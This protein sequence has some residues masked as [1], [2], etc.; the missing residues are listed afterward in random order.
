MRVF[1]V[2]VVVVVVFFGS[3]GQGRAENPQTS[4]LVPTAASPWP[5]PWLEKQRVW[6]EKMGRDRFQRML[7]YG[8][9][10]DPCGAFYWFA[11]AS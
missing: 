6:F 7:A 9:G 2:L 3:C 4:A 8:T 1:T 11:Y 10:R 5:D